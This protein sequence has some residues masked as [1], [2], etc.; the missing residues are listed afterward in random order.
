M[1]PCHT[2]HVVRGQILKY[3]QEDACRHAMPKAQAGSRA[4]CTVAW[5][6]DA[7]M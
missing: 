5:S 6:L 7:N 4:P 2:G 3:H 1:Q